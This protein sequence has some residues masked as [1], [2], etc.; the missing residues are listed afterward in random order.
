MSTEERFKEY[1]DS[2]FPVDEKRTRSAIILQSYGERIVRHLKGTPDD[3]KL[4]RHFVKKTQFKLLDLPAAGLRD[5]L[6]VAV[7]EDKRVSVLLG[8]VMT[9]A[10]HIVLKS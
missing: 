3:C 10:N 9:Q 8:L 4:F 6:V 5:V 7:K 1:L 2:K